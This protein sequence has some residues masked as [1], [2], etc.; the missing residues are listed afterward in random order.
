M[1]EQSYTSARERRGKKGLLSR[2]VWER[3]S[4]VKTNKKTIKI[5]KTLSNNTF[6]PFFPL[7]GVSPSL[8]SL[9]LAVLF[10]VGKEG[11]KGRR[12]VYKV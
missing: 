2:L 7:V 9:V 12:Q 10:W 3:R 5:K 11:K 6:F 8:F 4:R 1:S